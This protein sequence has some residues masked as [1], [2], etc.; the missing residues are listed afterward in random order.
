MVLALATLYALRPR[1]RSAIPP[2]RV[3]VAATVLDL[4][5]AAVVGIREHL[6]DKATDVS[7]LILT[8]YVP[9]LWVSAALVAWRLWTRRDKRLP[10]S[11]ASP[12]PDPTS[13]E[14]GSLAVGRRG[15]LQAGPA[16]PMATLRNLA[17]GRSPRPAG[18]TSIAACAAT[19]QPRPNSAPHRSA[20][21]AHGSD[22]TTPCRGPEPR[23][24]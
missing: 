11:R 22:I 13:R 10:S 14:A 19:L 24:A 6:F 9:A 2:A 16:P 21:H 3:F 23:A 12:A 1:W 5:N 7:W 8:F 15:R 18:S 4:S 20:S 17:V